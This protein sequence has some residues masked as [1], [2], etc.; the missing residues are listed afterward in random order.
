MIRTFMAALL[1][2]FLFPLSAS[3]HVGQGDV[4][5]GFMSGFMHPIMGWDHIIAMVSVGLWGAQLRQPA[6]WLLPITFPIVMCVGAAIG[7]F[8]IPLPGVEIGIA[9]SAIVLGTL[10]AM[11]A[12][13][14]LWVAAFIVGI[15]AIFHGHAHGAELPSSANALSF[16]LGF[17]IAT[18]GLHLIGIL[19]GT[20]HRWRAGAAALRAAGALVAAG[21]T[22][23]LIQALR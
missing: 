20:I 13:P 10:V 17:V 19:I 23:F 2:I 4:A 7:A 16:S 8:G 6:I 18:G 15:F 21:G 22:F 1:L 5:G 9:A 12:T 14:P 11:E 3:A